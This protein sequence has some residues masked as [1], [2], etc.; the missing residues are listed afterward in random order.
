[1]LARLTSLLELYLAH[2]SKKLETVLGVHNVTFTP[3]ELAGSKWV[4][5]KKFLEGYGK[6]DFPIDAW[7]TLLTL[8]DVRNILVHENGDTA[9]V[10]PSALTKI[11]QNPDLKTEHGKLE[12]DG[13]YIAHCLS[14]FRSLVEHVNGQID[15]SIERALQPR[16]LK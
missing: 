11:Q 13:E 8:I 16:D 15:Q 3:N 7:V 10:S 2:A 14:A 1:M 9:A 4:R 6:F 12:F 5:Y